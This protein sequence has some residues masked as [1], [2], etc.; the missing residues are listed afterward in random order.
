MKKILALFLMASSHVCAA[1]S[2]AWPQA[3]SELC[4]VE[5]IPIPSALSAGIPVNAEELV[6][7][8]VGLAWHDLNADGRPELFVDDG[9]GGKGYSF[10]VYEGERGAYKLIGSIS[11]GMI[12]VAEPV[13]G[14][15]QIIESHSSSCCEGTLTLNHYIN[16]KYQCVLTRDWKS[17]ERTGKVEESPPK[18]CL[19]PN[20]SLQ[21]RQP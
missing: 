16:G 19:R 12:R 1:E 5:S 20:N 18:S 21:A 10:A 7:G 11:T 17:N 6:S 2:P 4:C 14:Y 13:N 8:M 3:V 15:R 9:M